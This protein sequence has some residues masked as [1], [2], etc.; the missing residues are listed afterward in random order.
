MG[1][2]KIL[3]V[4]DSK[5]TLMMELMILQDEPYEFYTAATGCDAI[6]KAITHQPDLIL[7]DVILADGVS[8]IDTCRLLRNE[9]ATRTTPIVMVTSRATEEEIEEGYA[10]GCTSYLTKPIDDRE[11]LHKVKE[12][13]DD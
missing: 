9:E 1:Q 11:L 8:G 2:K 5:T 10:A 12:I 6:D 13:L 3:L 4:D 7:L